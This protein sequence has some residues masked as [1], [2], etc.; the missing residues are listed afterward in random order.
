VPRVLWGFFKVGGIV[1]KDTRNAVP[2]LLLPVST[3]YDC[4]LCALSDGP[5]NGRNMK[6]QKLRRGLGT[7]QFRRF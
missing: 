5:L 3:D 1:F 7:P 2:L 4:K 6:Q